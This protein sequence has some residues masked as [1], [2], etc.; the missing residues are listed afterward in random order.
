MVSQPATRIPDTT[1]RNRSTP[2][3]ASQHH[4]R[5]APHAISK[6]V[7]TSGGHCGGCPAGTQMTWVR[8][9]RPSGNTQKDTSTALAVH[10]HSAR[11]NWTTPVRPRWL[12]V[13][14][15]GSLVPDALQPGHDLPSRL[16]HCICLMM[17]NTVALLPVCDTVHTR[18]NPVN[19]RPKH[20]SLRPSELDHSS[21]LSYVLSCN[22]SRPH[23]AIIL[24]DVRD[25]LRSPTWRQCTVRQAGRPLWGEGYV[26][27][28]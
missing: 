24:L 13:S 8:Y 28:P 4:A 19:S 7:A 12:H 11:H 1:T 3:A 17:F 14:A 2:R 6:Q 20:V 18:R 5:P 25:C 9:P 22:C 23:Q 27:C 15:E 10:I 26:L 21:K 16:L